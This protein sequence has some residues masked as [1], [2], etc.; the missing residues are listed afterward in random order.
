M[1]LTVY[2]FGAL[3][4]M[5][6][7]LGFLFKMMYWKGADMLIVIG[8]ASAALLYVPAFAIYK[9]KKGSLV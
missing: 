2:V 4:A 6:I 8:L 9:Y 5:L 3:V 1:R 7:I